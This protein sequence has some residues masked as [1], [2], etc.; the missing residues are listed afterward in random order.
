MNDASEVN[1]YKVNLSVISLIA[2]LAAPVAAFMLFMA[3]SAAQQ[4]S[5]AKFGLAFFI[6][7]GIAN[8]IACV[9]QMKCRNQLL[10]L[11]TAGVWVAGLGCVL[12][13]EYSMARDFHPNNSTYRMNYLIGRLTNWLPLYFIVGAAVTVLWSLINNAMA[14][15]TK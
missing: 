13:A 15:L 8:T 14:K 4:P 9:I 1:T 3:E 2:G 5:I 7:F 12:Y 6:G 11:V 10:D